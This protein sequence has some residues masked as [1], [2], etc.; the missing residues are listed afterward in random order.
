MSN[1]MK[2]LDDPVE[3]PPKSP[4][5]TPTRIF[6]RGLAVILPAA[7]TILILI[8]IF[9]KVNSYLIQP[10]TYAVKFTVAS[11]VDESVVIKEDNGVQGLA[12]LERIDGGPPLDHCGTDYLVT[13]KLR[14]RF[15]RFVETESPLTAADL[16]NLDPDELPTLMDAYAIRQQRRSAWLQAQAD[17]VDSQIYVQFGP[18]AVP[19]DVYSAVA[20]DLPPGQMPTSAKAVYM[21]YVAHQ[22]LGSVFPLSVI[23]VC[24]FVV[25]FYFAGQFVS[26]KVGNFFVGVVENQVLGRLP[27][28]RNVYGSVKQVTD[29][30]FTENQPVEY[31]RVAG[32]QYPRKG[33]W[34]IGFVTGESLR[35]IALGAGEPCVAVLIPTSPMPMTG[36]TVSIPKSE[37]IDLDITV[38]QAMQFCISCG[39]LT[40]VHQKLTAQQFK[41]Y[42]EQG[43]LRANLSQAPRFPNLESGSFKNIPMPPQAYDDGEE[44]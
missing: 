34:T 4:R 33:I 20:R 10:A 24:I 9:E 16:E 28:V 37:V 32:V 38:E 25:M 6:L 39:V 36:F 29:F 15:Q 27:V 7:L 26:A 22:Y 2:P 42:V 23:T 11:V 30:I 31:R 5:L 19:Y 14:S 13:P 8:W 41:E 21:E 18:S 40:P 43:L 12:N 1:E 17:E 35:Q 44:D 3:Q